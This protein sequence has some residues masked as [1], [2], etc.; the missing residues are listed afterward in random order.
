[1][2]V[3]DEQGIRQGLKRGLLFASLER[4]ISVCQGVS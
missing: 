4:R 2:Y 1:M 3:K